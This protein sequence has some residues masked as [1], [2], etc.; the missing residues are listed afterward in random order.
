MNQRVLIIGGGLAGVEAA[1]QLARAGVQMGLPKATALEIAAQ[2]VLVS[3]KMIAESG[4]HPYELVDRVCSP[5]GTTIEGVL[6]LQELG[7]DHA[8]TQ[9]VVRAYERDLEIAKEK[10]SC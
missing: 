7:F 3:A 2:T 9:A 6:A 8:V 1:M 10:A 5:A 4:E